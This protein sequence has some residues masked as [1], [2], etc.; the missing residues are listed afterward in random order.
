[1]EQG[2]VARKAG[3]T[4]QTVSRWENGEAT[5]RGKYILP[6]ANA[7]E[8]SKETLTDYIV[9]HHNE[10]GAVAETLDLDL[11]VAELEREL[12]AMRSEL[13]RLLGA[14]RQLLGER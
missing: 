5:P 3:V 1:M 2:D 8:V 13:D 4:Q 6:L 10:G 12:G 7:L 11:R 9:Q 14:F